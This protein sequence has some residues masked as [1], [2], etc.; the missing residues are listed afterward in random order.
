MA[1]LRS[2]SL[3]EALGED[4]ISAAV[5]VVLDIHPH[6]LDLFGTMMDDTKFH[7]SQVELQGCLVSYD[8]S[9]TSVCSA[10]RKEVLAVAGVDAILVHDERR[11]GVVVLYLA[12]EGAPVIGPIVA[13]LVHTAVVSSAGE[14]LGALRACLGL[15]ADR[16]PEVVGFLSA[17]DPARLHRGDAHGTASGEQVDAV[18]IVG[19]FLQPEAA[20]LIVVPVPLAEVNS[21]V[22]HVV[23]GQD[24]VDGPQ[25][26]RPHDL[27]RLRKEGR[28][29][30][31]E[32]DD[33]LIL[34]APER[35]PQRA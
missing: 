35:L 29:T 1:A 22:R 14:V 30:Q 33:D 3:S 21:P 10:A 9:T 7:R 34:P 32:R 20:R 26:A 8:R 6:L 16:A 28:M 19:S 5:R 2:P 17:V 24:L 15:V 13:V 27:Q 25:G 23:Y 12:A 31:G 18:E 11:A 4:A